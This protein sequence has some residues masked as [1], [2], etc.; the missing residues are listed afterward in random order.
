MMELAWS[1][2]WNSNNSLS[3][4]IFLSL[5]QQ[6][7]L[8]KPFHGERGIALQIN[9]PPTLLMTVRQKLGPGLQEWTVE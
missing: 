5:S 8:F 4:M 2:L 3:V 7:T 6:K 9:C 1:Q